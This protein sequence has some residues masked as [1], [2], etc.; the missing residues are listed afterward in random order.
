MS[1]LRSSEIFI[2]A[3]FIY[4]AFVALFLLPSSWPA[5]TLAVCVALVVVGISRIGSVLRD[6][7]PLAFA[8][9]AYR[10]MDL[11]SVLAHDRHLENI[12]VSWDRWVLDEIYL[13]AAIESLGWLMPFYFELCYLLVYSIGAVALTALLLNGRRD[14]VDRLWLAYLAGTLGAYALFP[15][16]PSDPPRTI[17]PNSDLPNAITL[18]RQLNLLI[19]GGY[20]IHSSVFPSAHVSSALSAAWGLH[21]T[22]P[23]RPWISR[24][25]ALY[26]LSVGVATV[27]GRYHYTVDAVAGIV[28]SGVAILVL[29]TP[30]RY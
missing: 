26:G 20:G 16:F 21:A 18:P 22:L 17:F 29:R 2:I 4:V 23:Q 9:V 3:Y 8:L 30:R 6:W 5:W 15:F 12:W 1:L 24:C 11:F 13:R 28:L 19:V 10:E 25:M 14:Q 7:T 27:Y